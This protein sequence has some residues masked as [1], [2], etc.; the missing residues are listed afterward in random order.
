MAARTPFAHSAHWLEPR[1]AAVIRGGREQTEG[2]SLRSP[3]LQVR[4]HARPRRYAVG[5]RPVCL[6]NVVVNELVSLKPRLS[7]IC[8]TDIA[9]SANKDLACW[10]RM[11][12]T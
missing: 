4:S 5:V 7:P 8:V 3:E 2:T 6:R 10:M 1:P 12:L 9:G 11:L